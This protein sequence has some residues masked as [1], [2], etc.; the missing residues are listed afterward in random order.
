MTLLS[1]C[2]V[3]FP[4]MITN[5]EYALVY[6][7]DKKWVV[8]IHSHHSIA[9]RQLKYKK[10]FPGKYKTSKLALVAAQK[11]GFVTCYTLNA[12]R[13]RWSCHR[14]KKDEDQK[15]WRLIYKRQRITTR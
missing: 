9:D 3:G 5:E 4:L 7:Q 1:D 15:N 13:S 8:A 10:I 12:L 11:M 6:L 2:P 14:F